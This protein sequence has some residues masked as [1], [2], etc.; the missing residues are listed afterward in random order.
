MAFFDQIM[1][2]LENSNCNSDRHFSTTDCTTSDGPNILRNLDLS[3]FQSK[4]F[5]WLAIEAQSQFSSFD[6]SVQLPQIFQLP[7]RKSIFKFREILT[8]NI[9]Q[10]ES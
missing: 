7:R 2:Y 6:S 3:D 9:L 1:K 10:H 8:K 4:Y 5:D